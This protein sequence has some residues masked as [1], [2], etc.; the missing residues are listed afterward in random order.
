[1]FLQFVGVKLE[2]LSASVWLLRK[3]SIQKSLFLCAFFRYELLTFQFAVG[4]NMLWI[5]LVF[6]LCNP[7]VMLENLFYANVI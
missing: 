1:M 3:E 4:C 2:F 6:N 7:L 5:Q